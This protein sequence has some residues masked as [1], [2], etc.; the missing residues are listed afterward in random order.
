V[1]CAEEDGVFAE[2]VLLQRE[3][4]C[5]STGLEGSNLLSPSEHVVPLLPPPRIPVN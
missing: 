1:L 5:L 4:E 2:P 3:N